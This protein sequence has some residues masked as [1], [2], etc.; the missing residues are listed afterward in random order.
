M[1]DKTAGT[2]IKDIAG[3]C[4]SRLYSS[5]PHTPIKQKKQISKRVI[6]KNVLD[7]AVKVIIIKSQPFSIHPFKNILGV[8]MGNV[9]VISRKITCVIF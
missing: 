9:M 2:G 5:L 4:T 6:V 3:N 8:K 1:V 7:E